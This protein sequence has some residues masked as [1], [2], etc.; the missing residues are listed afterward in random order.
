MFLGSAPQA[1][2]RP[3]PD[4]HSS[5]SVLYQQTSSGRT[6]TSD[7]LPPALSVNAVNRCP[8]TL[9]LQP[10]TVKR[11]KFAGWTLDTEAH[12][13][14]SPHNVVVS[15]SNVEY[16]LLRIFLTYPNCVL[17]RDQLYNLTQKRDWDPLDRT[18]DLQVSRLR[19]KLGDDARTP[20]LIK[21]VRSEGYIFTA[22]VD[23]D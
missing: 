18:L 17:T 21:T 7:V 23:V 5:P 9:N 16:R 3:P 19:Q 4:S 10:D 1:L 11:Y 6:L 20:R 8:V 15:L 13:L 12:Y 2:A 22:L 14:L